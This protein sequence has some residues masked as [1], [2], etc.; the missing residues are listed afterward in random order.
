MRK[1]IID[2]GIMVA[3]SS[4]SILTYHQVMKNN[5]KIYVVDAQKISK[6][7]NAE[8]VKSMKSEKEVMEYYDR[9]QKMVEFSTN[10]MNKIAIEK[11][12]NIYAKSIIM[13][14]K[15]DDN[16]IDI[17]DDLI[18]TLKQKKLL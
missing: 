6:L 5:Q 12:T 18:I 15:T 11:D 1:M 14:T 4:V 13:N 3:V 8:L 10:Y 7:T 2:L 17:T 16:I 9:L